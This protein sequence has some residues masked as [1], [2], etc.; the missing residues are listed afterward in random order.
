ME[1]TVLVTGGARGIGAAISRAFADS[2]FRV[3][4]NYNRSTEAAQSLVDELVKKG[5][6][7]RA[8]K[9]DV[10]CA[11]DVKAMTA[12]VLQWA[13][14]IDVLVNNA[15][16]ASQRLFTDISEEEWDRM[17]DIN[18]KGAFLCCKNVLPGM[19]SK[20]KGKIVNIS[21]IWGI[22]GASCEVHYSASKAALIGLTRALARELGP[23][24]ITVNCV[25]PGVIETDM[26]ASLDEQ[27]LGEL[28]GLTPLG[29][30][31]KPEDAAAAVLFLA[32]DQAGFVTG[33]VLSPNGGFV[34]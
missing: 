14:G 17:F 23:S 5:V 22:S 34:I 26:N 30:L 31:G 19:I 15:G 9:A 28:I 18:V 13:G 25:A 32:S 2:G 6:K 33:Q 8:F 10:S 16:V 4:I 29:V 21:S 11:G 1:K 3:A 27:A 7:A 20:K 12:G 24:G